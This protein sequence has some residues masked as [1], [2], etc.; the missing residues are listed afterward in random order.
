MTCPG[1]QVEINSNREDKERKMR[2]RVWTIAL[3]TILVCTG[4][5]FADDAKLC[6]DTLPKIFKVVVDALFPTAKIT[7]VE[8]DEESIKV[9]EVELDNNGKECSVEMAS[10]GSVLSIE[11]QVTD[12]DQL[13]EAVLKAIKGLGKVKVTG[14]EKEEIRAKLQ[15]VKL[16]KPVTIYEAE[17]VKDGKLFD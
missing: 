8:V 15:V 14:I 13:P 7:E 12:D 2:T 17:F 1:R 9:I 4:A 6:P 3:L 11:T 10:D 16:E 5:T